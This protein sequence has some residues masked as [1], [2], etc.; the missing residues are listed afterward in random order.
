MAKQV[1]A[2]TIW[3]C[4][5]LSLATG[6]TQTQ[7]HVEP[8]GSPSPLPAV[9]TT[10]DPVEITVYSAPGDSEDSW[11]ENYGNAIKKKFPNYTIKFINPRGNDALKLQNQI[12]AGQNIDIYYESIGGFFSSVPDNNLQYDMSDLVKK[13]NLDLNR[14]EPSTIEAMKK[15][16][17]GQLW[18]IPVYTNNMIM[19]YNKD[20]FDTFAVPYPKDGMS[21]EEVLTLSRKLTKRENGK[22]YA[23]LAVSPAHILK[24]NPYSLPFIDAAS[25]QATINNEEKWKKMFQTFFIDPSTGADYREAI[26][27][28]GNKLPYTDQFTKD[29]TLAMFVVLSNL[30]TLLPQDFA[31]VNW[32]MVSAPAFNDLPGVGTQSYPTY[33]SIPNFSKHKEEAFQVIQF[34]SSDEVQRDNAKKGIMSILKGSEFKEAYGKE[35]KFKDKNYNAAF[36]HSFAPIMPKTKYDSIAEKA[37]TKSLVDL[38][39]GKIDLNTLFR[40]AEEETNKGIASLKNK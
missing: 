27:A 38:S 19:Y 18:G 3:L 25:G 10:K 2:S 7:N 34:L 17:G 4:A 23:G 12:V 40:N 37:Y 32:D 9:Q 26:Q 11:N 16:T 33:F 5:S 39:L 21:W 20:I 22:Q 35:S 30:P 8:T 29:Q 6:C 24:M 31:Q 1:L 36:F 13:Y 14:F 28:L 15:N